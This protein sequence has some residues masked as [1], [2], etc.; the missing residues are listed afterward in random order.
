ML[1]IHADLIWWTIITFVLLM[2]ILRKVA[3]RPIIEALDAREEA[4]AQAK[5]DA[6]AAQEEGRKLLDEHRQMLTKAEAE[7]GDILLQAR[8]AADRVRREITEQAN[9][10]AEAVHERATREIESAKNAALR[11]VRD[12][13]AD[14]AVTAAGRILGEAL[15]EERHRRLIDD[16]IAELPEEQAT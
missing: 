11:E 4:M 1:D 14:L 7:A 10:D 12:T 16:M 13:I 15:D 9:V 8:E 3:W 2:L 5:V 6:E